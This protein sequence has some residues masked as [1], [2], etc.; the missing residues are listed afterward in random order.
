MSADPVPQRI[1]LGLASTRSSRH[2]RAEAA[3][4]RPKERSALCK[5]TDVGE[6]L[7]SGVG[8]PARCDPGDERSS[9]Y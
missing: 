7:P 1:G 9:G 5:H 2:Q 8:I 6:G 3:L 4:P